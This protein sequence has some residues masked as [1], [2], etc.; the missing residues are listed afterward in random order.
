MV[1]DYYAMLGVD[2]TADRPVLESALARS[3]PAWSSGTRNP[4]TKHTYQSYL[5]QVPAL[6]QALLSTPSARAAYD[7]EVAA[8][9]R[10]ERDA[11]L[12][13]LQKKVRLR[14]AKGGLT[15]SDRRL[16]RDEAAKLGLTAE[17]CDRLVEPIP[18]RPEAPAEEDAPDP[19]VD[20]LDPVIRRQIR[21]ALDHLRRRDLYDA[22]GLPRDA[23]AAELQA[24][25]DAERQRWMKKTQVTAEKT[26]WLEVVTLAQSH[27]GTP[28]ARSRYDRTLA[29][30][31][32]EEF[33]EALSFALKGLPRLD[34]GT[35]AAV[36]EEAAALGLLPKRAAQ[37]LARACRAAGVGRDGKGSGS[38]RPGSSGVI[39]AVTG[40]PRYLR[41]RQCSGV[42]DYEQVARSPGRAE[43]RHCGAEL[44]WVCPVCRRVRWVDEPRCV[45]GFPVESG[46]PLVRHFE[47]AQDAFRG[48]DYGSAFAH[49]RRV[50]ELAP[51]HA[52]ARKAVEKVKE[53]VAEVDAARAA[54]EVAKGGVQLLAARRAVL[55]WGKLVDH[56]SPDWRA[57]MIEVTRGVRDARAFAAKARARERTDPGAARALYR[58]G[59]ALAADLPEA[60]AGLDR[61]PPDPP[62]DLSAVFD[63][64]RVRLRWSPPP[65]DGLGPVGFAVLRK[66][67]AALSHPADGLVIGE[68]SAP[69]F[70]DD[71]VA[72]GQLV[73]Y[74]VVSR[75]GGVD[76]VGAVAV[77]PLLLAADVRDVRVETRNREVDLSWTPPPGVTDVRVVRK[78]GG[79]P[80]GPQDGDRVEA[81]PDSAHDHGLEPDRV[82]HYGIFAVY[83]QADG[84]ATASPGVR[85]AAQPHTPVH[86]P[87]APVVS[88]APDGRLLIRWVEPPRGLVKLVRTDRPLAHPPG[89]RLAPAQVAAIVGDWLEVDLPDRAYD[90]PPPGV[91][92][93][94]TPLAVWAGVAAVG[95]SAVYSDVPDPTD[96]RAARAGANQVQLRWRWGDRGG[97]TLV[98]YKPLSPPAGA[99]DPSAWAETVSRVDYDRAGRHT[100]SLPAEPAGPWHL[101]VFTLAAPAGGGPPVTSPGLEPS[102]RAVVAAPSPGV[103][104]SY[105]FRPTG[106]LGRRW[107]VAF[108]TAPAGAAVPPTVLVSN[109]RAVPLSTDDGVTAASFPAAHDGATFP[110]PAGLNPSQTRARVFAD[111]RAE[112]DGLAPITLRHPEAD[113]ARV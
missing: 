94:Y 33:G 8:A 69:E 22:L 65:P 35:E 112:P 66:P 64:D 37:L 88:T 102:S 4:K 27:L 6:R 91:L 50:Q 13:L 83:R 60:K 34:P 75:R 100:L 29:V 77:G 55:A 32:E 24:R 36:L 95:R 21:V 41:C 62:S 89:T 104:L 85:V 57:A 84:Q 80:A 93:Y 39:N 16:L 31:A 71:G 97:Q 12:D 52:G 109:D 101:A 96:L 46:E 40:P 79:P 28:A 61:C 14:A 110:L 3:Q 11:R 48:R 59:L 45:C 58:K 5:D 111:P 113:P 86:A 107:S 17:D 25:A 44:H 19:A 2:P 67:D 47:A 98:V 78:R 49:L 20:T 1:P 26:A 105:A 9:R 73:A 108:A 7:A 81:L 72:P 90:A 15:V 30:A 42:T 63:R 76:S 87:E 99:E 18:P 38:G 54:Y 103:T 74:A 10:A 106:L 43:C 56:A 70:E 92:W 53:R 51:K 23:P 82:Y 68:T